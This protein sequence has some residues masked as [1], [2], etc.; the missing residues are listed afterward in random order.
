MNNF[1]LQKLEQEFE[2]KLQ[3]QNKPS[4][5]NNWVPY[6]KFIKQTKSKKS[7]SELD[8]NTIELNKD[9][10]IEQKKEQKKLLKEIKKLS[11]DLG[12]KK[13]YKKLTKSD[14]K[15]KKQL[16]DM[17]LNK[18]SRETPKNTRRKYIRTALG[19]KFKEIF[20]YADDIDDLNGFDDTEELNNK[21]LSQILINRLTNEYTKIKSDTSG[22]YSLKSYIVIKCL[23]MYV[24]DEEVLYKN[25]YFN[26]SISDI[27]STNNI[28]EFVKNVIEAFKESL[29]GSNTGSGWAFSKFIKFTIATQ[30][31]K[32]I[33][34]KSYIK[35]PQAIINKKA[36]VNIKNKDDKCFE[37][38][39]IAS[40][41]YDSIKSK[42][43]NELYHYKKYEDIIKRPDGQTFP[44]MTDDIHK[45]EELNDIQINVFSLDGYDDENKDIKQYIYQEYKSNIHR[46]EVVN[47]LLIREGDLSHYVFVNNINRLFASQTTRRGKHI[48]ENCLVKSF[49][50]VEL[51]N[52]HKIKCQNLE[53][54]EVQKIDLVYELPEEGEN[55]LKFKNH[56]NSF[57]HPF[58][59]IADFESTLTH[60]DE[61]GL[62]KDELEGLSTRKYQKHLQNSFGLKY[63]CDIEQNSKP[64]EIINNSNPEEVSKLFVESVEEYAKY[65]YQLLQGNKKNIIWK[66]GEKERHNINTNCENCKCG[67]TIYNKRVAHHNHINGDFFSSLCNECN[68]KFVYKPFIP[69][70]LHNLKGYDSHL[71]INALYKYGSK[72]QDLTC[73]PNNE[74]RY[75]SFS[76]NI[77]VDEYFCKKEKKMK[78]VMFEI[79]FLDSIAFMN[80]GIEKLVDNLTNGCKSI[81]DLRNAFPNTSKHFKDDEKFKLMTQKGVYPY[82][83]IDSYEKLN[84][85]H[86]PTQ[87]K[88]Y[89]KLY[90]SKCSDEDYKQAV[91]V[92]EKFECKTF[93]DYHNIYLKSDVLLLSDVW[94]AFRNTCYTN[95][96]L[97]CLYYYTAP[98]LSFDAMLKYTKIELELFTEVE[99]YEFCEK[100]IRGGLSQISKRHAVANNKYMSVYDPKKED[101]YIV[102]LDAN[103]L[104]GHS[105]SQYLPVRGFKWNKEKWS[106]ESIMNIGD[107]DKIG[108][109]FKVDLRIPNSLHEH[110]NNYVPCPENIQIKKN[111][112]N[113]WQQENYKESRVRKLCTSFNDKID[114][115]VDYRY[116]KLCLSLGVELL[117]VK[118]V[119]EYEQEPFLRNY[120]QLNTNLRTK[121]TNDFEKDFFKLMNN[122]VFG[123][124]MENVRNRINFRLVDNEDSAFRV[125]NL[126]RFTIFSDNLVGVH[127]QKKQIQLNKPV[128]LGQTILDDSKTLMYNF[129]YNFMLKKIKRENIDLLFTDTDSL[130]YHIKKEDIFEVMNNNKSY[131]DL[132]EY[133]K[134]DPLYDPTNKKV[135]GKFKNESVKQITEFVGL[136]AKLYAYT[137]DNDNKKHL[138]CKGVKSCV[139]KSELNITRYRDC[140]YSRKSEKVKQNSIRSYGHQL[141]TETVNKTALSCKDDKVYICDNN[142]DTRNFGYNPK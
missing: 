137:V 24:D 65:S 12:M 119:L 105:M 23:M 90:D 13:E 133:P 67:Y 104:Y 49:N 21:Y 27:V 111:D 68:L 45:Y 98:G 32:S 82:D 64:I 54:S 112:L 86:L 96:N 88:F 120:I 62:T 43:K 69:V 122:S 93:M 141:F 81:E 59:I 6:K 79:R 107:G 16:L 124:T 125:K 106:N 113:T 5:S 76:K 7:K 139:V 100:G 130:C 46:Q 71:F 34:G 1:E 114:Y 134:D 110:F 123:K 55:I 94:A 56:G 15:V 87:D 58:Y 132:S 11:Q 29:T 31:T 14:N 131:F 72:D 41:K 19:E 135:I 102:Y 26:S 103:N 136:R 9:L 66:A 10:I 25:H 138:K 51:L 108:Y 97:D 39:L 74:E 121:A 142:I 129:H 70:Y 18:N 78:K 84:I 75:I 101:S 116:L 38:C 89:S 30:K 115:V 20:I 22:K 2:S 28:K 17:K 85:D 63:C 8:K 61:E 92:W 128:Y 99:M 57:K 127:I 118:Q 3:G 33:F 4:T 40:K 50:S 117:Q 47:L 48:C 52:K 35:L 109:K 53:E 83:E 44:I 36:C 60:Y 140:L 95:Y 73:I 80:S 37:W 91:T 77:K 126:N 42:D